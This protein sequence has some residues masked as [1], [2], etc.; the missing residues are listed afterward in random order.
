LGA[1]NR[2]TAVDAQHI[3]EAFQAKLAGLKDHRAPATEASLPSPQSDPTLNPIASPGAGPAQL[4]KVDRI[5]KSELPFPEPRRV[6]GKAH[7]K[8][9]AKQPCLICGRRPS[10]AHHLRFAQTRALGRKVSASTL[11]RCAA[12]TITKS[13]TAATK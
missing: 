6:R 9:V 12:R 2:L 11:C 13:I 1:K 8:F 10:D 4:A 3:E 7:I 5:N